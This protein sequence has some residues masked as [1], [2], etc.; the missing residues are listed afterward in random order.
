MLV[1]KSSSRGEDKLREAFVCASNGVFKGWKLLFY[2]LLSSDSGYFYAKAPGHHLRKLWL[3]DKT[4]LK[5]SLRDNMPDD[6]LEVWAEVKK[7]IVAIPTAM[8]EREDGVAVA[9]QKID[10]A[11][12][13]GAVQSVLQASNFMMKEMPTLFFMEEEMVLDPNEVL[14]WVLRMVHS[15]DTPEVVKLG[16]KSFIVSK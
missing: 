13:R 4:K 10:F 2:P 14:A 6:V 5:V 16:Q 11:T 8:L 15:K 7:Q 12:E 9:I 1:P 3:M